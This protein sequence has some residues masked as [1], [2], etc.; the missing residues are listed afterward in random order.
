VRRLS[1]ILVLAFASCELPEIVTGRECVSTR[2]CECAAPPCERP[3][4]HYCELE[5]ED[6]ICVPL[7]RA[8]EPLPDQP[9]IVQS[10]LIVAL[11]DQRVD[12]Q[13][14]ALDPDPEASLGDRDSFVFDEVELTQ[15]DVGT[16]V[17]Q[18]DGSYSFQSAAPQVITRAQFQVTVR[19]VQ[20][21]DQADQGVNPP[22]SSVDVFVAVVPRDPD[23]VHIWNG[24]QSD[25]FLEGQNWD[26]LAPPSAVD[27]MFIN[28][29]APT[30]PDSPD[31]DH[32]VA[33]AY[34]N[35]AATSTTRSLTVDGPDLFAAGLLALDVRAPD[36]GLAQAVGGDF[37]NLFVDVATLAA[38]IRVEENLQVGPGGLEL[39]A[40][41]ASVW[42]DLV[43][44]GLVRFQDGLVIVEGATVLR[45]PVSGPGE[46]RV[47]GDVDAGRESLRDVHLRVQPALATLAPPTGE[48]VSLR[49]QR[50]GEV[51]VDRGAVAR[52][53]QDAVV[54]RLVMAGEVSVATDANLLVDFVQVRPSFVAA[55]ESGGIF[56]KDCDIAER[57]VQ[58]AY[59]HC[60]GDPLDGGPPD[61]DTD[62]GAPAPDAGAPVDAGPPPDVDP[63][64]DPDAGL[65]DDAGAPDPDAG[66]PPVDAGQDAGPVPVV[67][68]G[69]AP[70]ANQSK[71]LL[72]DR[73]IVGVDDSASFDLPFAA[74]VQSV[75]PVFF[76]VTGAVVSVSSD[77]TGTITSGAA[78]A[79]REFPLTLNLVAGA[80]VDA[81]V[82]VDVVGPAG[83]KTVVNP[84][85]NITQPNDFSPVGAP[86]VADRV[87]VPSGTTLTIGTPVTIGGIIIA[88]E[89]VV[90][91][92]ATGQLAIADVLAVGG[93]LTGAQVFV[94]QFQATTVSGG[95]IEELNCD[96]A[97][98]LDGSLHVTGNLRGA[99]GDNCDLLF[100]AH[101]ATVDGDLRGSAL[102]G[103]APGVVD[104]GGLLLSQGGSVVD[105]R[106]EVAGNIQAPLSDQAA[107]VLDGTGAQSTATVT[108]GSLDLINGPG[109]VSL[110]VA[111]NSTG[112]VFLDRP[113]ST[114]SGTLTCPV[115]VLGPNAVI[116][117]PANINCGTCVPDQSD[118][119]GCQG[120]GN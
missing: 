75:E 59:L 38:P 104:V 116:D 102:N 36:V 108:V 83:V 3:G 79:N 4:A 113:I 21:D 107:L 44:E 14:V 2:Q 82:L 1:L 63:D 89:G 92:Q 47:L 17:L 43:T 30:M 28:Y 111:M 97:A 25:E 93:E 56:A 120:V 119:N 110:G 81:C 118:P 84:F 8:I 60:P 23:L 53:Q 67:P 65:P 27:S 64:P 86:G 72:T 13:L 76:D 57:V 68:P 66:P 50:F 96:G 34:V 31:V 33:S 98:Q 61:L 37:V 35:N 7:P 48:V 9:T 88:D 51:T 12:G 62:A 103:L 101:R 71:L 55:N 18:A 15:L 49:S 19:E 109:T 87:F 32:E 91:V 114:A 77:G 45:G 24:S 10:G 46:L 29:E 112:P 16:L 52:F 117:D 22:E 54:D 69:C 74:E 106:F 20:T 100:G 40:S 80:Q 73:I 70:L 90:A 115:I 6:P 94:S 95:P 39:L 58:P 105:A 78:A 85:S 41:V 99:L 5:I 11:A 42:G 26:P